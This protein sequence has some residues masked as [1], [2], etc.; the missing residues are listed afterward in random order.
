MPPP[1][2]KPLN[3][4]K[5]G[6]RLHVP[7]GINCKVAHLACDVS[8][9]CKRCVSLNKTE[10][11]QDVLHKKRGRPK[12][13]TQN[14]NGNNYTYDIIYGTIETPAFPIQTSHHKEIQPKNQP[15]PISFVHESFQ[16]N[17]PQK[18]STNNSTINTTKEPLTNGSTTN[19]TGELLVNISNESTTNTIRKLLPNTLKKSSEESFHSTPEEHSPNTFSNIPKESLL[20]TTRDSFSNIS[21][22]PSLNTTREVFPNTLEDSSLDTTKAFPNI[23]EDM[24]TNTP[25][26]SFLQETPLD[27]FSKQSSFLDSSKPLSPPLLQDILP[28]S[29]DFLSDFFDTS[30]LDDTS[31]TIPEELTLILSMEICCAQ[32][33]TEIYALWGYHPQELAHRSLYDFVSPDDTHRLSQL[34]RLLLDHTSQIS[35]QSNPL[36]PAERST[37]TL[38]S[39][40]SPSTLNTMANGSKTFSDTIHI[41]QS[42][43]GYK[44]Y[45]IAFFVGGGLGGDLYDPQTLDR[46]YI[47]A[48]CRPPTLPVRR[49]LSSFQ[50]KKSF[51]VPKFNMAPNTQMK[52]K[53]SPLFQH[54]RQVIH[55]THQYFLQ[56]SSSTLNAAAS[57]VKSRSVFSMSGS[58]H[59]HIEEMSINSLLC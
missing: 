12:R 35:N 5:T 40:T 53:F 24:F 26:E 21:E 41:R 29:N 3:N 45:E 2:K 7:L 33:P 59:R 11:C 15:K 20:D 55:P 23:S 9:P 14:A 10:S 52:P 30:L 47:V 4:P 25:K 57:A 18:K 46:H 54:S 43:G 27:L 31:F 37:S 19:T 13:H 36:P 49:P 22:G 58:S 51:S 28:S 32:V 38:F 16:A 56:T 48:H 50:R 44:P 39:T 6:H 34:H 42:S 8:R 1:K 17:Q